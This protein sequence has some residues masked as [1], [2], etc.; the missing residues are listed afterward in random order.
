MLSLSRK[1]PKKDEKIGDKHTLLIG[2]NIEVMIT[3]VSK[4][5]VFLSIKAPK[6]IPIIRKEYL[7]NKKCKE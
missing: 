3:R 6:E 7:N 5:Q 1:I 4:G 2:D